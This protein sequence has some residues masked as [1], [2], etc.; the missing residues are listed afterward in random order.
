MQQDLA[1]GKRRLV[2][3]RLLP[4]CDRDAAFSKSVSAQCYGDD[5]CPICVR[6]FAESSE[7]AL[8]TLSP[9]GH[10][11]HSVCAQLLAD[12]A[13]VCPLCRSAVD[14]RGAFGVEKSRMNTCRRPGCPRVTWNGQPNEFCGK[15]CRDMGASN[16][17]VCLAVN[18][19][20]P[21]WNGSRN[22]YCSRT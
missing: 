3:R 15:I 4:P 6:S 22:D 10:K 13:Q 8:L 2:R 7:L 19:G 17:F 14:W 1:S 11:L 5:S 12:N 9:C 16:L 20:K 18:C 21:T